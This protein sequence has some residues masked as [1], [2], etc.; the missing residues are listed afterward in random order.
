MMIT[1]KGNENH[2]QKKAHLQ[3]NWFLVSLQKCKTLCALA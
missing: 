2:Q 1:A 3:K